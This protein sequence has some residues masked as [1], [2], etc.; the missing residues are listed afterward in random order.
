MSFLASF[1]KA[2]VPK[3]AQPHIRTYLFKAGITSEPYDFFGVLF[4]VAMALT[5]LV[6]VVFISPNLSELGALLAGMV[7]FFSIAGVAFLVIALAMLSC[8]FYLD[9]IIYNRTK[10]I[11]EILP[12]YL[13]LVSTNIKS[14][15]SFEQ[16]LWYAIKPKFGI[17]ATEMQLVLKKVMTGHDLSDAL[18]DF[19]KK[20]NSHMLRRTMAMLVGELDSGGQI[21]HI[22]DDVVKNIKNNHKLKAEMSASAVTYIIFIGAIVIVISPVL[23]ALSYN[24]LS[25][26]D[27]FVV[28]LAS[29]GVSEN[30]PINI[31][32]GAISLVEF[33]RFSFLSVIIVAVLSSM[34]VSIV[35]KGN[36]RGGLKYIPIFS[37]GGLVCYFLFSLVLQAI[38][39]SVII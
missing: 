30:S 1:G 20:Y 11:E 29:S 34:I 21:G 14:G 2:F 13:Q 39:G 6:Y 37:I 38:F 5:G 12:E 17:L 35:E 24:L 32:P 22:I 28:K 19:G 3:K 8:Y 16:S 10:R 18:L 9:V 27:Q 7:T 4:F 25:F 26:I 33:Q 36:I 15:L 31:Q 23:F